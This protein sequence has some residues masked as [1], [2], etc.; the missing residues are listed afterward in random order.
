MK[1]NDLKEAIVQS[2]KNIVL[3]QMYVDLLLEQNIGIE[4]AKNHI[5][6]I[7]KYD[8]SNI[9]AKNSFL[10]YY[11]KMENHGAVIIIGKELN[12]SITFENEVR[13]ATSYFF[14]GEKDLAIELYKSIKSN[15]I[16]FTNKFLEDNLKIKVKPEIQS[17]NK[18]EFITR[19]RIK[20]INVGGMDSVKEKIELKIIKPI[21]HPEIFEKY[22]K[23]SGGGVLMYGPPGCGKTYLARASA[24]E[25]EVNFINVSLHDILD[26]WLGQ[27]EKNLHSVFS[28]A[29][30]NKPCIIFFD[31]IDALGYKRDN[32]SQS[33][34]SNIINQLLVEL[35]GFNSQN[36]EIL[37]IGATNTPWSLDEALKRSG[38]FDEVI[39][40][41]PPDII[42]REKI[43]E[44][45]MEDKPHNGISFENIANITPHYS[46]ADLHNIINRAIEKKISLALK[47]GDI[48]PITENDLIKEIK[49]FSPTTLEWFSTIKNYTLFANRTGIYNEVID[50]MKKNNLR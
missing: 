32:I 47:T 16:D 48:L 13:L 9:R 26:L 25:A 27:S 41:S 21:L 1:I 40:I 22:G 50:Y 6:Y 30:N 23:K 17:E 3:R 14:N 28:Q 8:E 38:R 24:G 15:N 4:E 49:Q 19:P 10:C 29:R 34:G 5:E 44:I 7:L 43:L 2:P 31:E 18:H 45:H 11:S 20:F 37:I 36:E 42:A 33:K 39:F 35:D 46:G 12:S